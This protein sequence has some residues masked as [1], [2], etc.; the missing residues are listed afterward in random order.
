VAG[1]PNVT[2]SAIGSLF[3]PKTSEAFLYDSDGNLT[4]DGR[5]MYVWDAENRLLSMESQA[6]APTASKRKVVYT[7]DHQSRMISRKAYNGSSGSYVLNTDTKWI[8]DGWRQLAEISATNN[9]LIRA[10]TWGLDLSGGMDK[11]GGIGGLLMFTDAATAT[12]HF[13]AYDGNGNVMALVKATD[14]SKTADYEYGPFGEV[15]R[16]SGTVSKSNPFRFSTKCQDE[17]TELLYYGYR[18]Y[19]ASSGRWVN[20]DPIGDTAFQQRSLKRSSRWQLP[21]L[22]ENGAFTDF[23]FCGNAPLTCLDILGLEEVAIDVFTII[24][25]PHDQAGIK[26][27]HHVVVNDVGQIVRKDHTTGSTD[28]MGRPWEGTSEFFESIE[29]HHPIVTVRMSVSSSSFWLSSLLNISYHYTITLN[30]CSRSGHLNGRNDG[31]P[32]YQV[33]V[34]GLIYDWQQRDFWDLLGE[35]E[36]WPVVDFNF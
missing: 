2:N 17:E 10:F 19:N 16:S 4:N 24:R 5:W 18:F 30:F 26:T 29:V 13:C 21:S 1:S 35:G 36:I 3:L 8:Y 20:R 28:F 14:G 15:L 9:A 12:S 7:Y 23:S 34:N 31:F 33:R 11:A 25:E 22:K 6:T 32:S 27:T